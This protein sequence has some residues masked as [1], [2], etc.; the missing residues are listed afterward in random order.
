VKFFVS[1]LLDLPDELLVFA[2]TGLD[3]LFFYSLALLFSGFC[4]CALYHDLYENIVGL[5]NVI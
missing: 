4:I 1:E 3:S 2:D 5:V